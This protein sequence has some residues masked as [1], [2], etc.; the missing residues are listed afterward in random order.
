MRDV[1]ERLPLRTEGD[2]LEDL[3]PREEAAERVA[4]FMARDARRDDVVIRPSEQTAAV[5]P[6][7]LADEPQRHREREHAPEE[8]QPF[9][10]GSQERGGD[11]VDHRLFL[12]IV[13]EHVLRT[14]GD[15][16][17]HG[18]FLLVSDGERAG[19]IR[20]IVNHDLY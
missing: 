17:L 1:A 19:V 5:G 14:E 3:R 12:L 8:Q 7:E 10:D 13:V 6:D 16:V 4:R 2:E 9:G 11:V 20:I 18:A 15:G